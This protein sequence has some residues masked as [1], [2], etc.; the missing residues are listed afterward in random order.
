VGVL[1][2]SYLV[3]LLTTRG[4]T[5]YLA[6][7]YSEVISF[8]GGMWFMPIL[9]TSLIMSWLKV[10]PVLLKFVDQGWVEALGGQGLIY[11]NRGVGSKLDFSALIG[12]K[13][14]L[15]GGFL[16][17]VLITYYFYLNSS[18]LER[19]FEAAKVD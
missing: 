1:G 2:L 12:L 6:G 8:F 19:G 13:M 7:I 9:S 15:F 10:G 18:H 5:G 14:Y 11:S 3:F 4:A 16:V 17:V